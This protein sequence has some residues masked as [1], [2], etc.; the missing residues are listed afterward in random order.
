MYG[1]PS[2]AP[3]FEVASIKPAAPSNIRFYVVRGGPGTT[4][5]GQLTCLSI[6]LKPLLLRAWGIRDYQLVGPSSI[7]GDKFDIVAKI[8]PGS[9]R[10]QVNLMIQN[11]LVERFGLAFHKET[12]DLPIYEMTVAKGGLKLKEAEKPPEGVAASPAPDRPAGGG[13][14]LPFKMSS[15]K[16]GLPELPPGA[17]SIIPGIPVDGG[18]RTQGRMVAVADLLMVLSSELGRPVVEKSGVTGLWDFTLFYLPEGARAAMGAV[19]TAE[20]PPGQAVDS[21]SNRPPS[22]FAALE[23]QLGLKLESKKGPVEVLVVDRVNRTPT[24][25]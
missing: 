24:E 18:M 17:R 11:L 2:V 8:P 19:G 6:T 21:L 23:E 25:N 22:L 16:D 7:D 10:E 12:R 13:R 9:T 4:D 15:G 1:Q 5:P 14:A 20:P 3:A